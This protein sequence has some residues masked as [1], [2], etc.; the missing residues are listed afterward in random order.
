MKKT[1]NPPRTLLK[2]SHPHTSKKDY[3]RDRS[4]GTWQ[5]EL[6]ANLPHLN[7]IDWDSLPHKTGSDT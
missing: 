3:K 1:H 6:D 5:K 7:E 4:D 2:K